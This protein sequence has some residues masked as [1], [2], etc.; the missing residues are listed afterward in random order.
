MIDNKLIHDWTVSYL[1]RR[2]SREYDDVRVNLDGDKKSEFNGH[3]PDLILR[4]HGFVMAVIEVET[5]DSVT[6]EK[7]GE[8]KSLSGLG[9]KLILMVPNSMKSKALDILWKAGIADRASVGTY[10]ISVNMP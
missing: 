8:W 9:A 6:T 10:G 1:S 2:L 4:N 7:A 3:Y 5:E